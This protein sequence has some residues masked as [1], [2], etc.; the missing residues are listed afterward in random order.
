MIK[1]EVEKYCD[2]CPEFDTHVEKEVMFDVYFKKF[3]TQILHANIK[4]NAYV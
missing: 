4:I 2:N 3:L 1:L